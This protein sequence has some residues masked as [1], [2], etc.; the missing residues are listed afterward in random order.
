MKWT[1]SLLVFLCIQVAMADDG[2]RVVPAG[3]VKKYPDG[4]PAAKYRLDA[5]DAGVI[6]RHGDGPGGC[7]KLGA[8]EALIFE[9]NGVYHLFYDAPGGDS[10][11][12]MERDLGLAWLELPL[13][14]ARQ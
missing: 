1:I 7:D 6:L 5:T 12:H 14:P 4:R 13:S 8:R 2:S 9:E 10:A 11:S 3:E